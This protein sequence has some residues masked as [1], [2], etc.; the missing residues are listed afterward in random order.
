MDFV[1]LDFETANAQRNSACEVGLSKVVGGRVVDTQ[2]WLINPPGAFAPYNTYLHG[3]GARQVQDAPT[4]AELWPELAAYIDGAVIFAH[5]ASFDLSVLRSSLEHYGVVAPHLAYLCSVNVARRTWLGLGSYGLR[6]LC[7][8][9]EIDMGQH[10]RAGDDAA[11]CAH[12][13][14]KAAR[15]HLAQN[16]DE[17]AEAIRYKYGRLLPGNTIGPVS[18]PNVKKNAAAKKLQAR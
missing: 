18:Y 5:N 3:I 6:G 16:T 10:H 15:Y 7:T 17:L 12:I 1:A 11:S 8:L 4:F 14:L 13:V 2:S 9:H